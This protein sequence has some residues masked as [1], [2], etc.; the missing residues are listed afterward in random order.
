M[1]MKNLCDDCRKE[2]ATCY[3]TVTKWGEDVDQTLAHTALADCVVACDGY[4]GPATDGGK[5]G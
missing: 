2:F 1:E 4:V 3:G 5:E